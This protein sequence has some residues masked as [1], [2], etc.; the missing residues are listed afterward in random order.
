MRTKLPLTG[1]A[2]LVGTMRYFLIIFSCLILAGYLL[3]KE[4]DVLRLH[5]DE[6]EIGVDAD[7]IGVC[8]ASAHELPDIQIGAF[9]RTTCWQGAEVPSGSIYLAY[10]LRNGECIRQSLRGEFL[11]VGWYETR[12]FPRA[13]LEGAKLV[14]VGEAYQIRHEPVSDR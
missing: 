13:E 8:I 3:M 9:T 7:W 12:C 4:R 11:E 5:G 6:L 14:R 1:I 10:L 2:L